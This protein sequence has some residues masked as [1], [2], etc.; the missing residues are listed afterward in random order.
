M[1]SDHFHRICTYNEAEEAI[2]TNE[3]IYVNDCFCR[4][5]AKKGEAK[6]E[7]CGC[8]VEVC[9]G[10]RPPKEE[11][12]FT[13]K[14][15]SKDEALKLMEEWKK[16]GNLFRFM[17]DQ[18]WI[19]FCCACGCGFFRDE[20]GKK[21]K[22]TGDKAP[23][24]QKTDLEK[25]NLCDICI[26]ICAYEARSIDDDKMIVNSDNCAGCSACEYACPE[27]AISMVPKE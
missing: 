26:D 22:D 20:D 17:E 3:A 1:G 18:E 23:F 7:Y 21:T 8:P 25:C 9:M 2:R 5:P 4:G 19:C 6:W 13:S 14:P 24:I 12:D 10:F 16:Q 11:S 27:D 15:I